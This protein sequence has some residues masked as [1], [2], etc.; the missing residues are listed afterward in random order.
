M[1]KRKTTQ[2]KHQQGFPI[3]LISCTYFYIPV[4]STIARFAKPEAAE[5]AREAG[6]FWFFARSKTMTSS[7]KNR[8]VVAPETPPLHAPEQHGQQMIKNG[9]KF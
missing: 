1:K 5:V 2:K 4:I 7:A 9:R 3:F 8:T 6:L